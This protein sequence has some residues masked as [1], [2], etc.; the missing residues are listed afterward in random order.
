MRVCSLL[1]VLLSVVHVGAVAIQLAQGE[2]FCVTLHTQREEN[3]FGSFSVTPAQSR[4][5]VKVTALRTNNIQYQK[6]SANEGKFSHP[7]AEEGDNALCFENTGLHQKTVKFE[8]GRESE[9]GD[10]NF[11]KKDDL[12]PM[13]SNLKRLETVVEG[14]HDDLSLMQRRSKEMEAIN[15]STHNRVLWTSVGSCM[16]LVGLGVAQLVYLRAY[17][18]SKKILKNN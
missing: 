16:L 14:I 7:A 11:A 6:N 8:F 3:I 17:F 4:I 10:Q 13:E 2:E 1:T 9:H 18:V 12:K 5:Q 15:T